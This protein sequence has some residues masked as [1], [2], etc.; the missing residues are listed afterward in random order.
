MVHY[1][2]ETG[3]PVYLYPQ[4]EAHDRF[5]SCESLIRTG[6]HDIPQFDGYAVGNNLAEDGLI[7]LISKNRRPCMIFGIVPPGGIPEVIWA[8]LCRRYRKIKL[9]IGADNWEPIPPPS[10][11]IWLASGQIDADSSEVDWMV[12][13]IDRLASTLNAPVGDRS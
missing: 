1:D 10:A 3:N 4:R 5:E 11:N 13:F 8:A 7:G 9:F 2:L 6:V 12:P